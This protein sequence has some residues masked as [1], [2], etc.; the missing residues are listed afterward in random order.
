M[1]KQREK[2]GEAGREERREDGGKDRGRKMA[3]T[4]R[5]FT[6]GMYPKRSVHSDNYGLMFFGG[7]KTKRG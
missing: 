7:K 5:P 2:R 4:W 3:T 1:E 6:A